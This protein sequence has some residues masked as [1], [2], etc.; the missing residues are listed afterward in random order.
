MFTVEGKANQRSN[1]KILSWSIAGAPT[2]GNV[3]AWGT[4]TA[5]N[6]NLQLLS[7]SVGNTENCVSHSSPADTDLCTL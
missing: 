1:G 6:N 4:K 2:K 3:P 5:I 7:S